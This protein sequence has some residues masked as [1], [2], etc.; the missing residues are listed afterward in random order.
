MRERTIGKDYEFQEILTDLD[1][2]NS[3][4][5][6]K[7][8]LT[9][10]FEIGTRGCISKEL[11]N[12]IKPKFF[13]HVHIFHT[14]DLMIRHFYL[15]NNNQNINCSTLLDFFG[16]KSYEQNVRLKYL[17][18]M[19]DPRGGMRACIMKTDPS[20]NNFPH[21]PSFR[22]VKDYLENLKN[23]GPANFPIEDA[24]YFSEQAFDFILTSNRK[25]QPCYCSVFFSFLKRLE[26]MEKLE[27]GVSEKR[28][29]LRF[30]INSPDKNASFWEMI[31]YCAKE[32]YLPED[33][34]RWDQFLEI[35]D[36]SKKSFTKTL[37][38]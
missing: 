34:E 22:S 2:I 16:G 32:D 38:T 31:K 21:H 17:I 33:L 11:E 12:L 20:L 27:L 5:K 25:I 13:E 35:F 36:P 19:F 14:F 28:F 9:I 1:S 3:I 24:D 23:Q 4:F 30:I 37:S 8:K 26:K 7:L 29:D 6:R 10:H 18:A 15:N